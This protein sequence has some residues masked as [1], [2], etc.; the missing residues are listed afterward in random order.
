LNCD[1]IDVKKHPQWSA[2]LKQ[3]NRLRGLSAITEYKNKTRN[4]NLFKKPVLM[5]NGSS[6]VVFHK[7]INELLVPEFPDVTKKE[8]PGGHNA[9]VA[10]VNEFIKAVRDFIK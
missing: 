3:K 2:W 9:P 5:L 1:S 7:R 4:L 6:T 8:I 10:S